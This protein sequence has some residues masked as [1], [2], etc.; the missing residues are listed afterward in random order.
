MM[1]ELDGRMAV[2]PENM[3]N[4]T[5]APVMLF[6]AAG[7]IIWVNDA[8]ER[9]CGYPCA[10][11]YAASRCPFL[12]SEDEERL[13]TMVLQ[14][15][16]GTPQES[17]DIPLT[18]SDYTIRYI[19]WNTILI[20]DEDDTRHNA[21]AV[22]GIETGGRGQD[23]SELG[24]IEDRYRII[25][26]NSGIG[27]MYTDEK[28]KIVLVNKEFEKATGYLKSEVEGRMNWQVLIPFREDL[29]RMKT[30]H[31]LRRID[32]TSAPEAYNTRILKRDGQMRDMLL[33]VIMIPGTRNSLVAFIDIT[34]IRLAEEAVRKSEE[35]YRALVDNMQNVLYRSDVKGDLTFV[36]PS[37]AIVL[38]YDSIDEMIGKNIAKDLYFNPGE[39]EILINEL[40]AYGKV[41]N[42]EV[43]L[44]RKD[45]SPV[46]IETNSHFYYDNDGNVLGIEGI[47]TD[48]TKRKHA[49]MTLKESEERLRGITNNIP[50]S[51][52]QFY[53]KDCGE[54]G[55]NYVSER[56]TEMLDL[57]TDLKDLFPAML[58]HIHEEDRERF[59]AS[60]RKAVETFSSWIFEGRFI[61]PSGEIFWFHGQASPRHH[62]GGLVFDGILLNITERKH[63]EEMSRQS[64]EKFTKIFMTTPDCIAITRMSDGLIL[65]VNMGFEE[66]TGWKTDEAIG[67]TSSEIRFWVNSADRQYMV[68]E[69]KSGRDI[70]HREFQF[71]RKDGFVRTGIH[72]ARPINI[73]GEECL[74]F[75]L[76]DTTDW[77]LLAEDRRRLEHQLSQSQKLDAIGQLASGVAHDFNNILMGILGNTSL[78]LMECNAEHPYYQRLN[79]I[80]EHVKRG[81][82]L[83]RQLLGFAR[84]GK[85]EV[86]TLSANDLIRKSAQFFL[87]SR[88]EID[89]ELQLQDDIYPV[90]ADGGQIEQVLLNIYINA[91][92]AMPKG[93]HL[94]I[95]TVNVTLKET[96]AESFDIKPGDY[97]KISI[98]DTGTGMS[99]EILKKIFEPFFTTK[100]KDGGTGLGLASAYGIIRNHGGAIN[101]SSVL[102]KGSIFEIYLPSSVKK[103]IQKE[104][105]EP[106]RK[107][108]YGSGG[109]LLV[110]DEP[111][112]LELASDLL[113]ML[114]YT[115]YQASNGQDAA[116]T[117]RE[118]QDGI[119]LVILDMILPGMTG[120][121]VLKMLKD[122][123]PDV[124]V[125]LSSG[126][127]FQGEV[128]RAMEMG[129][130]AFI[131]K[132]YNFA[133]M[134]SLVHQVLSPSTQTG[135]E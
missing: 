117:Y 84:E 38:G 87:E 60:I 83:T 9:L 59:I 102:G 23:R 56:L 31:T 12:S 95:Q 45:G 10:D 3:F 91:G 78:M 40:K 121:Q 110:D 34:E 72:S 103:N 29:E 2:S 105:K 36:S 130:T 134:S 71:R 17:L 52:F 67:H 133:D 55:M 69:L 18:C 109:I 123:N 120:T 108:L 128:Q 119:N 100:S 41:T 1:M 49:E 107:L 115:V 92:H 122:I 135:P 131:Q 75:V 129:C 97:V 35:N 6:N 15:L 58:S 89:A 74:I 61:L 62:E 98:S 65:D 111:M 53:A 80:E 64:E 27:L 26:E 44:K 81:S 16:S 116:S 22:F 79:R 127:G 96:D 85:Y 68:N 8:L 54:F 88:K 63:A 48:I 19:R 125:I 4:R 5:A 20:H 42:Y 76:Q 86:K 124:K 73:A 47:F 13:K 43:T 66:I 132:P 14:T 46:F 112:I 113:K 21:V 77:K 30:Y 51:I 24:D 106:E 32:P 33:R 101:A 90:E 118:R 99:N 7:K 50:G 39:R 114:G 11:L 104:D 82:N 93:G 94:R 70:L 126:Y 57:P 28:M 37:G 25:F